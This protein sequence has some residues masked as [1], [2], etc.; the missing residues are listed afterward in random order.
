MQAAKL[1]LTALF[2]SLLFG[3]CE[4]QANTEKGDGH[5]EHEVQADGAAGIRSDNGEKWLVN[6]EM[7]PFLQEAETM[8]KEYID[9]GSGE[10]KQLANNLKEKNSGLIKSCTMKGESHDELHKWLHPHM[11]LIKQLEQAESAAAAGPI[12]VELKKSFGT[13]HEFFQ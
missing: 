7:K 3:G 1:F 5:S 13:Y 8:L 12:I 10:Y 11:E 4:P 6:E 2:T 9:T